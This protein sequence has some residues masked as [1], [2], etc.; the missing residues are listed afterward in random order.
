MPER[1]LYSRKEV[2]EHLNIGPTTFYKEIKAGRLQVIK[3]GKL[4]RV[5]HDD[6]AA[7]IAAR[8][9]ESKAQ[10]TTSEAA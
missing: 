5:I 7:Y 1:K 3:I 9:A 10:Q 8:L 4:T 2:C 6:V